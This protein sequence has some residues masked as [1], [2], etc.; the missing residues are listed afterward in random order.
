VGVGAGAGAFL[1]SSQRAMRAAGE[2]A[3]PGPFILR[4]GAGAG[5]GA[6]AFLCSS[7]RA[8]RAAG[9]LAISQG[10]TYYSTS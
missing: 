1:C 2:L 10:K 8:M 5:A 4:V 3:T 7:Q 9:E 6:S